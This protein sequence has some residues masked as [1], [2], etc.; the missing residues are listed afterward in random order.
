LNVFE[1]FMSRARVVCI[2]GLCIVRK[3][4]S[5]CPCRVVKCVSSMTRGRVASLLAVI[6]FETSCRAGMRPEIVG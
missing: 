2:D 3:V 5:A 1:L 6:T 4:H